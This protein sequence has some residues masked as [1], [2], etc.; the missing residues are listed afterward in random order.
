MSFGREL[1]M[2]VGKPMPRLLPELG[3]GG[4]PPRGKGFSRVPV[5]MALGEIVKPRTP[6]T[7]V[8]H[9]GLLSPTTRRAIKHGVSRS[10][11][12]T[13]VM[14]PV[15]VHSVRMPP[16]HDPHPCVECTN[17]KKLAQVLQQR[18]VT[19]DDKEELLNRREKELIALEQRLM[20]WEQDLTKQQ[21]QQTAR[22]AAT[23]AP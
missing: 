21:Q 22:K 13:Y 10:P 1:Q 5:G 3:A 7:E 9:T 20:A 18:D 17:L 15:Q 4:S 11:R 19:L 23:N 2:P 6:R 14:S 12:E 8:L 16:P